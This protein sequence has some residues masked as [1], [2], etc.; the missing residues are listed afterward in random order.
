MGPS[1][2]EDPA[3]A[4]RAARMVNAYEAAFWDTLAEGISK[5]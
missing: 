3:E 2:G 5:N 1:N 4:V